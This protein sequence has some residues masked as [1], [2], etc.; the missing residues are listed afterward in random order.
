LDALFAPFAGFCMIHAMPSATSTIQKCWCVLWGK[1]SLWLPLCKATSHYKCIVVGSV[2][3]FPSSVAFFVCLPILC[4]PDSDIIPVSMFE[5]LHSI[6]DLQTSALRE[7]P[8]KVP[9]HALHEYA[10]LDTRY[11]LAKLSYQVSNYTM[12][13]L[14]A[15]ALAR[16]TT[17]GG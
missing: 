15:G 6:M 5:V 10:Q 2:S 7:C 8:T 12:G 1:C 3:P 9:R 16:T 4:L 14:P 11:E 13:I 17:S